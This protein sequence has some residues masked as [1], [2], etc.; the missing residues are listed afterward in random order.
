MGT[1][2]KN[3]K[4]REQC[5]NKRGNEENKGNKGETRNTK[6]ERGETKEGKEEQRKT[7]EQMRYQGTLV[8]PSMFLSWWLHRISFLTEKPIDFIRF[9]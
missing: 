6:E 2:G 4:P 8:N 9:Y 1:K 3:G 5:K 7:N